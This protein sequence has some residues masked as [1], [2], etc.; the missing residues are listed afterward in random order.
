LFQ[1]CDALLAKLDRFF[2]VGFL[3]SELLYL[4]PEAAMICRVPR[5]GL[6]V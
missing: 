2:E 3:F 6:A 1:L 4:L 5:R